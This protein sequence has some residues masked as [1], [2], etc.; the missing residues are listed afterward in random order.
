LCVNILFILKDIYKNE[1]IVEHYIT[2]CL[3]FKNLLSLLISILLVLF[4]FTLIFKTCRYFTFSAEDLIYII[5]RQLQKSTNTNT[6]LFY[7]CTVCTSAI[8]IRCLECDKDGINLSR[9]ISTFQESWLSV[10]I[11][12]LLKPSCMSVLSI[13]LAVIFLNTYLIT[14]VLNY[15]WL[16]S[17]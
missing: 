14:C 7:I 15:E 10:F 13:S 16:F 3:Q 11:T 12:G 8:I 9:V 4:N 5:L 1:Y 2:F 17:K 6:L